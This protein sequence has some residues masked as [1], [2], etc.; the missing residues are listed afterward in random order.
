M[1]LLVLNTPTLKSQDTTG[2]LKVADVMPKYTTGDTGLYQFI[3]QNIQYPQ[4]CVDSGIQGKVY[5]RFVVSADGTVKNAEVIKG[6][7]S[8]LND[9]ATRVVSKL[10]PFIPGKNNG[11]NVDVYYA[12]PITFVLPGGGKKKSEV[13]TVLSTC[14]VEPKYPGGDDAMEKVFSGII[15]PTDKTG[16]R[17][18]G[19]CSVGFVVDTNGKVNGLK[20]VQ[21]AHNGIDSAALAVVKELSQFKPALLAGKKISAYLL[22]KFDFRNYTPPQIIVSYLP[23]P[24]SITGGDNAIFNRLEADIKV[25]ADSTN[26]EQSVT[27]NFRISEKG[28]FSF[29][30]C[31]ETEHNMP[32]VENQ[33]RLL[34]PQ[35]LKGVSP[36]KNKDAAV[37]AYYNLALTY[38]TEN[39]KVIF[40]RKNGILKQAGDITALAFAGKKPE[41]PEGDLGLIR[42]LQKN[43]D[44]P[45]LE[46]DNDIQG[47]V[48]IGF[49]I[50]ELG[51]VTNEQVIESVSPGLDKEAMR[52]AGLL[53]FNPAECNGE[54]M[55]AYFK[56]P[57]VYKLQ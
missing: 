57:V 5:V 25:P 36:A 19:Q 32:G 14:D 4:L 55:K 40:N 20:I 45:Q 28:A 46:R 37:T 1:W 39:G 16:A 43:I 6:V 8:L 11:K 34:L 24:P 50:N 22:V 13:F 48:V 17:L 12:V 7:C 54:K 31:R 27:V 2:I 47:R 41:F 33:V 42:F 10:P 9:E 18:Q 26:A 52:V 21:S 15:L 35:I 38:K 30:E 53:K 29:T 23:N 56:L 44:Y 49:I 3:R 51:E